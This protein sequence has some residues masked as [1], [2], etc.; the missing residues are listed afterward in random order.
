MSYIDKFN[1][2]KPFV[3]LN[4]PH[5]KKRNFTIKQ[6]SAITRYYNRLNTLGYL[7]REQ[8]GYV[9]KNISNSNYKIKYAPKIKAVYI[10]VGTKV[11]NGRIQ[12][13]DTAE[14]KIINGKINVRR[15]GMPY[16]WE[17]EYNIKRDWQL[18]SF[19]KH[20]KKQMLPNK[21]KRGQIFVIG[22]GMYEMGGSSDTELE[23]LAKEILR[24]SNKYYTALENFEREDHQA[25]EHF[26]YRIVV[27][28]NQ[29]AYKLRP[30][31][32]VNKRK[33]LIKG[34]RN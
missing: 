6:K 18:D 26:M 10:E 27:Y 29:K 3:N 16:K 24:L 33:K 7:N 9:L 12:T 4:I 21:P 30:R 34:K 14:I 19:V 1:K 13:D 32:K 31:K 25:P 8:E 15:R 23:S 20:L 11:I 28:E 22:A 2:I 17:F 5:N